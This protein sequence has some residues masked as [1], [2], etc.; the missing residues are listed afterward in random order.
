MSVLS[1]DGPLGV[2]G[3]REGEHLSICHRPVGGE[4][5]SRVVAY[6]PGLD[7]AAQAGAA[8]VWFGVNPVRD[9]VAEGRRGTSDDV[10]RLAAVWCD[11]DVK[12]GACR[13]LDHAHQIIDALSELLGTRPSAVVYSGGGLQP[14]WPLSRAAKSSTRQAVRPQPRR[15]KAG[16]VS[17]SW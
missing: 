15:S 17:P 6:T 2:L 4:F 9:G 13:D 12:P 16:A 7:V 10:T 5:V 8:C 3:C 11:L 1:F 14:Y